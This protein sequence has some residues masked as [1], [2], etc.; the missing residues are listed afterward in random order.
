MLRDDIRCP[1]RL[2][3]SDDFPSR[4]CQYLT[5]VDGFC[6]LHGNMVPY[7]KLYKK[8]R[9][10]TEAN[11]LPKPIKVKPKTVKSIILNYI[12]SLLED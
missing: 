8:T 6:P 7:L 4:R 9:T 3:A 2:P 10:L 11:N 1:I 12:K 5:G